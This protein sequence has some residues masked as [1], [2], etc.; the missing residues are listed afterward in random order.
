MTSDDG[1]TITW[2]TGTQKERVKFSI[3][4]A[5]FFSVLQI[6]VQKLVVEIQQYQENWLQFLERMDK[7]G[8][9]NK[10]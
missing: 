10:H 1:Q 6:R 4:I 3:V 7:N 2:R 9:T 8:C 5:K